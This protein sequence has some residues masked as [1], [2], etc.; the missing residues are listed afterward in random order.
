MQL[1]TVPSQVSGAYI[2]RPRAEDPISLDLGGP[3]SQDEFFATTPVPPPRIFTGPL[4]VEVHRYEAVWG[5]Q[6]Y[7]FYRCVLYPPLSTDEY[8]T[9]HSLQVCN[10]R[11]II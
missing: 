6:V 4:V 1:G 5:G 9:S 3:K 8:C 2:F 10:E 7:R 11:R